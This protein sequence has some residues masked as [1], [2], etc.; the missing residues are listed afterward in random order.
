M[1]NKDNST[2]KYAYIP[3]AQCSKL[4][5]ENLSNEEL[6]KLYKLHGDLTA[7]EF[8]IKNNL[9]LIKK[10]AYKRRNFSNLDYDDLIQEGTIGLIRGI[11]G[12]NLEYTSKF[13]TY[14]Y[15]WIIQVIERAIYTQG[16]IIRLP[17]HI[18][19]KINRLSKIE[20]EYFNHN[21]TNDPNQICKELNITI[22]E[23][24]SLKYYLNYF[25]TCASLNKYV[26]DNSDSEDE[27]IDFISSS[28]YLLQDSNIDSTNSSV[29]QEILKKD[30]KQQIDFLL[31]ILNPREAII[32]KLRFGIDCNKT[33]TLEEIGNIFGLTRER[34]R[35]IENRALRKLR[36]SSS[37]YKLRDFYY[38]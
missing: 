30:L 34:I 20:N 21:K 8:L 18:I 26:G 13:S 17:S 2:S 19:Q 37:I 4:C 31:N 14:A 36:H 27:L 32:I 28:N 12:F 3:M 5:Y 16:S 1:Y 24:K 11:E 10:E 35:Q 23:Y 22:D 38:E 33:H 25:K 15:Y 6:I 9:N 29:E 7:K